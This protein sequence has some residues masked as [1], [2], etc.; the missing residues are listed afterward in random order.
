MIDLTLKFLTDELNQ[1][2]AL[3][4]NVV[5][6]DM[7]IVM[8][9]ASRIFDTDQ[10]NIE[11]SMINKGVIS[12]VN[13]EE[14]RIAKQQENFTKTPDGIIYKNPPV[15]LNLYVLFVMNHKSYPLALRWLSYVIQFFQYQNVFTPLTHP[16]LDERVEKI[17]V[18]LYS[19]NFEQSNQLWNSLGG[20]YLPSALYKVRQITIDENVTAKGGGVITD[21]AINDRHKLPVS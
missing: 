2:L 21:I 18:E 4:P 8:G 1:Y 10:N 6:N 7:S 9:N 20:K 5:L 3:K 17:A 13:V 15:Y 16:G 12:L 11:I 14:D 19:Q